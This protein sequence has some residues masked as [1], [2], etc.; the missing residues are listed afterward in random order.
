MGSTG[1]DGDLDRRRARRR[2]LG[3]NSL[4]L[5]AGVGLDR[6][7]RLDPIP[8]RPVEWG[9]RVG[10]RRAGDR[11]DIAAA[12]V[13][14]H[15]RAIRTLRP[16]YEVADRIVDRR[17]IEGGLSATRHRSGARDRAESVRRRRSIPFGLAPDLLEPGDPG[18]RRSRHA[19]WRPS[20]ALRGPA[21]NSSIET[22]GWR[23]FSNELVAQASRSMSWPSAL[24][25]A[26]MMIP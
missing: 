21:P 18:R 14:H 6:G 25:I 3:V 10:V 11:E 7:K 2:R 22:I 8:R 9:G 23:V 1:V 24:P 15:E 17:P 5:R 20:A 4:A 26:A 13:D 12:V 19:Q 16:G